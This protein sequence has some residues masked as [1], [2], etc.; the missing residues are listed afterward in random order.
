MNNNKVFYSPQIKKII[1]FMD[2]YY[3]ENQYYPKLNE[4]GAELNVSK[5]RVGILI[6]N[7][8]RLGLVKSEDVFMRKYMLNKSVK[9]SK[10]KVNNYY[11]L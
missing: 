3:K 11:E 4:I 6:K 5:Q 10:F 1:D 7:A 2:K 9:N 8:E